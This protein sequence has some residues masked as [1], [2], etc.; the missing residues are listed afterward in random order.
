MYMEILKRLREVVR[1]KGLNFDP[2]IQFSAITM[3]QLTRR[4]LSSSFWHKN[5]LLKWNTH[6]IPLIWLQITSDFPKIKSAL[7]GARFQDSE[8]VGKKCD[9]STESY[10]KASLG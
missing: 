9:D 3:L 1:R 7:K 5:R 4:S 6:P 8:D 2:T 10:S